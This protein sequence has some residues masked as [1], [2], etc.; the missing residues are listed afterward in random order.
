MRFQF[1]GWAHT[2]GDGFVYLPRDQVLCTGDVAVNGPYNFTAD[3]NIGN[4]PKV[5]RAAQALNPLH[6]LPGH[7]PAGGPEVLDGQIK[8]MY[9]L[10]KAVDTAIK[11]GKKLESVVPAGTTTVYGNV[12]PAKTTLTLPSSLKNWIGPFLP[13]QVRDTWEEIAQKKPHGDIP[14]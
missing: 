8:F 2:R 9:E 1:F 6:V 14:H 4:W 10:H 7:G 5:L 12:V 3:A 13:A 11:D